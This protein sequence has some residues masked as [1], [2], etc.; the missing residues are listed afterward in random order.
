VHKTHHLYR[1]VLRLR[2]LR[3]IKYRQL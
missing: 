2:Q 3:R 1:L